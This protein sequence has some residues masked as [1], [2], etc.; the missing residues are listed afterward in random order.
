MVAGVGVGGLFKKKTPICKYE[1]MRLHPGY[2]QEGPGNISFIS[3]WVCPFL[4][5]KH[6]WT[7]GLFQKRKESRNMFSKHMWP[8]NPFIQL[9]PFFQLFN[10]TTGSISRSWCLAV[11]PTGD[12]RGTTVSSGHTLSLS[13]GSL[14]KFFLR[15]FVTCWVLGILHVP[16][17]S[18]NNTGYSNKNDNNKGGGREES[19]S[20]IS[21]CVR[22]S[23]RPF[24]ILVICHPQK[25]CE[26]YLFIRPY[27]YR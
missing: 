21:I 13:S 5:I 6:Q 20:W 10:L 25:T 4:F 16:S 15:H 23:L 12:V 8:M 3:M 11:P 9:L 7:W 26:V 2:D 17:A 1:M 14:S 22:H 19:T 24:C 27:F 18:S